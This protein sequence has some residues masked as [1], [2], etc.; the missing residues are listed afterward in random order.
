[1]QVAPHLERCRSF[2]FLLIFYWY[3][4]LVLLIFF[5]F[6]YLA[7]LITIQKSEYERVTEAMK[8][9]MPSE[10]TGLHVEHGESLPSDQVMM[11][12][13]Y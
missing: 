11:E 13:L 8:A 1:M 12:V 9:S 7:S 5:L 2:L 4:G 10:A 6:R 3:L